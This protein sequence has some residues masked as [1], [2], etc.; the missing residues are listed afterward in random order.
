MQVDLPTSVQDDAPYTYAG[1]NGDLS[2]ITTD[3]TV[4]LPL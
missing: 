1:A 3:V 4:V 2:A